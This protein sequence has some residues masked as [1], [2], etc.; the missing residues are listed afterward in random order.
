MAEMHRPIDSDAVAGRRLDLSKKLVTHLVG[1][2]EERTNE[3]HDRADDGDDRKADERK[4]HL[5]LQR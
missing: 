3:E 2:D 4:P 5:F 1:G